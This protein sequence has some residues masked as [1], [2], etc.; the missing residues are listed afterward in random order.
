[1]W[2]LKNQT[3]YQAERGWV[4]DKTGAKHWVVVVKGTF[5]IQPDG[6]AIPA[7]EPVDPLLAPEYRGEPGKTSLKYDG[8]LTGPKPGT[9]VLV[10][11]HAHSRKAVTELPIA[12]TVG[13]KRKVLV[14]R[15]DRT[16][17][18]NMLGQLVMSDPEPFLKMPVT[19]ERAFGGS[20]LED[21]DPRRQKIDPKNP[22]GAGV[23]AS[24][25]TLIG[26]AV[27]NIE[28]HTEPKDGSPAGYGAVASDWLP[29][30]ERAGTYDKAWMDSKRPLLPDDFSDRF[31]NC[32]PD[33]QQFTPHLRGG[34]P[35]EVV[36]MSPAGTIRGTLPRLFFA[37]TTVLGAQKIEHRAK[38]QTVI[39]EPDH[40]RLIMVWHTSLQ[41]QKVDS[42]E[43]T[44][45][46]EKKVL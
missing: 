9:D 17:K 35:F 1:M 26:K 14:V 39:I 40:P 28:H 29:R 20:D 21:P 22:V 46:R 36:N 16:W 11:G 30:R 42:L 15:G 27:P 7:D 41:C 23:A 24:K 6:T 37:F 45:I 44:V 2:A 25:E 4:V 34:E 32:A 10:E 43:H 5:T 18:K 38:L 33:D 12:V 19:Y 31:Y 13:S 8:D 3:S